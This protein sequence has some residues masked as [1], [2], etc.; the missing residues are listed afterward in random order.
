MSGTATGAYARRDPPYSPG[1]PRD[2]KRPTHN[3][4]HDLMQVIPVIRRNA[5][6]GIAPEVQRRVD[7]EPTHRQ[8]NPR[9][10]PSQ[11]GHR[12]RRER[13]EEQRPHSSHRIPNE[14][15]TDP[16]E[17][18]PLFPPLHCELPLTFRTV[19]PLRVYR[20]G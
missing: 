18:R 19:D 1:K 16:R 10:R 13:E 20:L 3:D 6:R 15:H 17:E 4:R 14:V 11:R 5:K 7:R 12:E 8:A 9:R 2:P